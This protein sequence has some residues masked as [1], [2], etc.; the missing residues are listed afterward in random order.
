MAL[1]RTAAA[2][3]EALCNSMAMQTCPHVAGGPVSAVLPMQ[4]SQV[5][6]NLTADARCILCMWQD[7]VVSL[8]CL[9]CKEH[10]EAEP[11]ALSSCLS[12][13]LDNDVTSLQLSLSHLVCCLMAK[14]VI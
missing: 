8:T 7:L 2:L 10:I 9:S 14:L 5:E 11:I 1:A 13:K 3:S 6:S 12:I 4:Q